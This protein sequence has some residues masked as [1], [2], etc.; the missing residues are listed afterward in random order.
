M[1]IAEWISLISEAVMGQ[2]E[3][4]ISCSATNDRFVIQDTEE[5]PSLPVKQVSVISNLCISNL[6]LL[7]VLWDKPEGRGFDSRWGYCIFQMA[8][9]MTQPLTKWL[10][11]IFLGTKDGRNVRL[12]TS[13]P[14]ASRLAGEWGA[15]TSHNH[16]GL[17]GL[18]Q[19]LCLS[20]SP[21][22]LIANISDAAI[23][24]GVLILN[25]ALY[26]KILD[27]SHGLWRRL[28][29]NRQSRLSKFVT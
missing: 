15:S 14:S 3:Q 11:G 4:C 8:L 13:P 2:Q 28:P 19:S 12:S 18:L 9:G 27:S 10:P 7:M 20:L 22:N 21:C 16:M 5:H 23:T 25:G 6:S 24:R 26:R 1:R 17:H 29:S